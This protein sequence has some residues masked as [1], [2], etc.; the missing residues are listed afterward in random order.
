MVEDAGRKQRLQRMQC[1][2]SAIEAADRFDA[3]DWAFEKMIVGAHWV[4]IMLRNE[5][6]G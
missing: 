1:A 5:G 4:P 3:G 2:P 6:V